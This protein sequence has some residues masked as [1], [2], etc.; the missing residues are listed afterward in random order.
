M[1]PISPHCCDIQSQIWHAVREEAA[2]SVSDFLLR[3]SAVG[4]SP[5]QGLD[6]VDLVA[7]EMGKLLR[8]SSAEQQRQ[9][10]SY[11]T[12]VALS[13]RFRTETTHVH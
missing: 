9:I 12:S 8:W 10:E 4:L 7:K 13:Q 11:R 5:C 6:A 2:L 3:R 1:Q